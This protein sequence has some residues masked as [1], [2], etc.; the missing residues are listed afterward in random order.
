MQDYVRHLTQQAV[1]SRNF[2]EVLETGNK[3][4]VVIMSLKPGEEI[5]SEIHLETE[6]V[7]IC[8]AGNGKV[9]IDDHEH[10][11]LDGDMVLVRAGQKHNFINTD[12]TPMKI[13]TIYTPP[14]HRDGIVHETKADADKARTSQEY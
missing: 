10:E 9:V 13:V 3:M 14:H 12:D 4:Q 7:L 11:Y 1:T 5:G 6:Q 8:L 2:R